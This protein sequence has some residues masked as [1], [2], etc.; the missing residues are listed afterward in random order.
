[1]VVGREGFTLADGRTTLRRAR[2][3]T[4]VPLAHDLAQRLATGLDL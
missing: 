2:T 1:M 3:E 4:I